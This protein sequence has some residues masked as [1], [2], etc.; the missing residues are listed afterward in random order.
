MYTSRKY[1]CIDRLCIPI[2]KKKPNA[3]YNHDI[4]LYVLIK[5]IVCFFRHVQ[6][7][8]I[9]FPYEKTEKKTYFVSASIVHV[10]HVENSFNGVY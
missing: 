7:S 8:Y 3:L 1:I 6:K 10:K 2:I 9:K 4:T 5:C